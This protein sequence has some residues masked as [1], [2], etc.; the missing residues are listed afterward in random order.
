[1]AVRLH[2]LPVSQSRPIGRA[3]VIGTLLNQMPGRR[4]ITIVGAG[5]IGQT[6]Y[7]SIRSFHYG[8]TAAQVIIVVVTVMAIDLAS[9]R[10]RRAL[11]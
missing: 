2:N 6:L 5:G 3:G 11:V 8:E 1:M 9:A 7:E 4:F 10:L